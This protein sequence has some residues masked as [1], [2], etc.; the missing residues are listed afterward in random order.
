MYFILL[1]RHTH[2]VDTGPT[3]VN[4][5]LQK[6]PQEDPCTPSQA[7]KALTLVGCSHGRPPCHGVRHAAPAGH[8]HTHKPSRLPCSRNTSR[9]LKGGR[10]GRALVSATHGPWLGESRDLPLG[11]TQTPLL[12]AAQVVAASSS[13]RASTPKPPHSPRALTPLPDTPLSQSGQHVLSFS[14]CV[15]ELHHRMLVPQPT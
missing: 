10:V 3:C 1:F 13:S 5:P 2:R 7:R 15:P 8:C 9:S 12:P 11:R 4:A 14:F 6:G